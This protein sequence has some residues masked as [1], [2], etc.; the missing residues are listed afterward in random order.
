MATKPNWALLRSSEDGSSSFDP[1]LKFLNP[2]LAQFLDY[3][4]A[5]RGE[6][7]MPSRKD[8]NP[9]EIKNLLPWVQMYDVR[10]GA[11]YIRLI[12]TEITKLL[13]PMDYFG[14][15]MTVFPPDL[16]QRVLNAMH[17][18]LEHRTALRVYHL[19]SAIPDRD[20]KVAESCAAPL[21]SN[22]VDIDGLISVTLYDTKK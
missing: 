13:P 12:G 9:R 5:I 2:Q 3:W 21:S 20:Y 7:Q 11:L 22:G 19:N 4:N 10:D 8:I 6:R 16:A 1:E 18:V 15:P 17:W 14:K